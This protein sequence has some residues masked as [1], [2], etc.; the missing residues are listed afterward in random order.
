VDYYRYFVLTAPFGGFR[1]LIKPARQIHFHLSF[2][3]DHKTWDARDIAITV[4]GGSRSDGGGK[5]IL[6]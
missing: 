3:L 5:T 2:I 4:G 6:V 1:D